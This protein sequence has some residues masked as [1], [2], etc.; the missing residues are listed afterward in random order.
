MG[1]Y[2]EMPQLSQRF[3]AFLEYTP[4]ILNS[5]SFLTLKIFIVAYYSE[6]GKVNEVAV[7]VKCSNFSYYEKGSHLFSQFYLIF[8][9]F[10]KFYTI[11]YYRTYNL[12]IILYI[13]IITYI[14]KIHQIA[15]AS[16]K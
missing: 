2:T 1:I 8:K 10:C 9:Y 12:P 6:G 14:H 13:A 7:F 16:G 5:L 4:V 15:L 11:Q 3:F